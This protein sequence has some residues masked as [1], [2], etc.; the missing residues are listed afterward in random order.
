MDFEPFRQG[1]LDGLCGLY[2]IINLILLRHGGSE[3]DRNEC[4]KALFRDG[5]GY[6]DRHD[7]PSIISHWMLEIT[8]ARLATRLARFPL[9]EH[10]G[11]CIAAHR[12]PRRKDDAIDMVEASVRG[13]RPVAIGVYGALDHYTVVIRVTDHWWHFFDS[14]GHRRIAKAGIGYRH[15]N[16]RHMLGERA[17]MVIDE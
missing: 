4:G 1:K 7:L 17:I 15:T 14:S 11:P 5:I 10:Q 13:G 6:L 2:A 12:L 3:R 9:S 16:G 8:W